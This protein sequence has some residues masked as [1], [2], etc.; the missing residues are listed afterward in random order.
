MSRELNVP[1]TMSPLLISPKLA[2]R[3]VSS[4]VSCFG[5]RSYSGAL[6]VV[7]WWHKIELGQR[8]LAWLTR[9]LMS[10]VLTEETASLRMGSFAAMRKATIAPKSICRHER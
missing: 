6:F 9:W 1:N 7:N 4:W 5:G 2:G 8:I 10:F 3:S